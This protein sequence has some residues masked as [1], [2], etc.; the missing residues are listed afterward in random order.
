MSVQNTTF[1]STALSI[2]E[3]L[4]SQ[5][6]AA[7]T[8]MD[9]ASELCSSL[10]EFGKEAVMEHPYT[11][12]I[13][14]GALLLVS[15]YLYYNQEVPPPSINQAETKISTAMENDIDQA[16]ALSDEYVKGLFNSTKFKA[17][18]G[19][20]A[21]NPKFA[22]YL[23]DKIFDVCARPIS[24]E[25]KQ[26]IIRNLIEDATQLMSRSSKRL[27]SDIKSGALKS[28]GIDENAVVDK[29]EPLGDES[30]NFGKIPLL[31]TFKDGKSI[32]YKPRS[33]TPEK[34]L[35]DKQTGLFAELG[36]GTY[37]VVCRTDTDGQYGYAEFI[38]NKPEENTVRSAGEVHDYLQKLCILDKVGQQL[39]L[40]DLHYL[41]I[42]TK[43][44][45]PFVI[46]AE[47][48]LNPPGVETGIMDSQNGSAV[49]FDL[50]TG[51]IKQWNGK[52]RIWFDPSM[53][54]RGAFKN[55]MFDQDLSKIGIDRN[56]I[57]DQ[58]SIAGSIMAKT[59]LAKEA[60]QE[61]KGR[62]VLIDTKSLKD[63]MLNIDPKAPETAN[64]LID[65][66]RENIEG[67]EGFVF[68]DSA[69]PA[70][71]EQIMI[72]AAHNDIP[73]FYINS[74]TN[75]ILYNGV[76]IGRK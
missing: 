28:L 27:N 72:D 75:E 56:K 57:H 67:Y 14:V 61:E 60:L 36:F 22:K 47:V 59:Q 20:S 17:E 31:I 32:V 38:Q 29:M 71:R 13:T 19:R 43:N 66:I 53:E 50:S 15:G 51:T 30:H 1:N 5:E 23:S 55:Y 8:L 40:S 34:V 48:F 10:F 54:T 18:V 46:D 33:M 68:N 41:N 24:S 4:S 73:T 39:G 3:G 9:K 64:S 70:I 12:F 37:D 63:S 52:N 11:S 35:C 58:T 7:A 44:K 42:I 6:G 49:M 65:S 16:S 25:G 2:T 45:E 26:A 69:I 74:R 76:V 62:L 21:L